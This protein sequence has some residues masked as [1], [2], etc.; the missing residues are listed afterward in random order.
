MSRGCSGR[1]CH[2][3]PLCVLPDITYVVD[4]SNERAMSLTIEPR[5]SKQSRRFVPG[6]FVCLESRTCSANLTL[7]AG[8]KHKISFLC[9]DLTRLW[10]NA[11]KTFSTCPSHPNWHAPRGPQAPLPILPCLLGGV[12]GMSCK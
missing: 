1:V 4:L 10:M 7:T 6:C 2:A 3:C 12:H 11:E 5:P 8:S 9:D